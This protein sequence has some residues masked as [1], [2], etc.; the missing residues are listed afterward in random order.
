[1]E[2]KAWIET[3]NA[4]GKRKEPC[5]F[6]IDF[7]GEIGEIYP[8]DELHKHSI[9][10]DFSFKKK[11]IKIEKELIISANPIDF[12]SFKKSFDKVYEQLKKGNT[13]LTN[14][15]FSTP[16]APIDLQEVYRQVRAKYK[17][18]YKNNWVCFSPESFLK[19][20][21][22]QVFTYPMKGTIDASLP[23]AEKQ[24]LQNAKETAEHHTIVDLLRND[25]SQIADNVQVTRF[26]YLEKIQ[27]KD[28]KILQA[29][30]E[31][32]GILPQNWASVLGT[33]LAKMLPAGSISGAPKQKTIQIITEAETH[34]RGFYTGIAGVFDGISLDSC[35]LIR[36]I[37]RIDNQFFYKSGGGITAQSTPKDEYDEIQQKIYIPI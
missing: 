10:F 33:L 30:S 24:L 25:L 21:D 2:K 4:Y 19:I 18:L 3:L 37:E 6:L 8:I 32:S 17:I 15:T 28:R 36:F 35:V 27:G 16:I 11:E 9:F 29:S 12:S 26:R 7:K 13:F 5:F 14:L 34:Q 22:N 23:D 20:T 1:M 31:I